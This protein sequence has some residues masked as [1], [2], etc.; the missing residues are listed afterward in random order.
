MIESE[1]SLRP[2]MKRVAE[3]LN[4]SADARSEEDNT[5]RDTRPPRQPPPSSGKWN[6]LS[7]DQIPDGTLMLTP[8]S[9]QSVAWTG[10]AMNL[11]TKDI[12][13]EKI[14]RK[15]WELHLSRILSISTDFAEARINEKGAKLIITNYVFH[16]NAVPA[17]VKLKDIRKSL[18][19]K[20][21]N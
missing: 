10:Y 4:V 15:N 7:T 19:M 12:V 13:K 9:L 2:T 11:R 5:S 17:N 21:N 1:P 6:F 3:T 20:E 16:Q 18:V 14:E 8:D